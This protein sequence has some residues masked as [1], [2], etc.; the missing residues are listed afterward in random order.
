MENDPLSYDA[1]QCSAAGMVFA[2]GEWKR[3]G[4]LSAFL[5]SLAAASIFQTLCTCLKNS[6]VQCT[7]SL[8]DRGQQPGSPGEIMGRSYSLWP[9]KRLQSLW[10][11]IRER[12]IWWFIEAAKSLFYFTFFYKI[13]WCVECKPGYYSSQVIGF[14]HESGLFKP[15]FDQLLN[16]LAQIIKVKKVRFSKTLSIY[17]S[18]WALVNVVKITASQ[19]M[20]K[21]CDFPQF[22]IMSMKW[23]E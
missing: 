23:N 6:Q 11:K 13:C 3:A 1:A 17:C 19:T 16:A 8:S 2:E 22:W 21:R 14:G 4:V 9:G 10:K 7:G 15:W 20:L 12:R 18:L 5:P